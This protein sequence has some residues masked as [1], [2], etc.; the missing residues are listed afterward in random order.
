VGVAWGVLFAVILRRLV[1]LLVARRLVNVS[2]VEIF[3][4]LKPSLI[5]GSVML[6]VVY[7]VLWGFSQTGPLVQLISALISGGVS[8]LGILWLIEREN[9]AS[10]VELLRPSKISAS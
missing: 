3:Q 9:F 5:G 1:S 4:E 2:I 10:F 6:V 7:M 8:Y